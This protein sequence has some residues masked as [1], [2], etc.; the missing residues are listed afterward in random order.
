MNTGGGKRVPAAFVDPGLRRDDDQSGAQP[1]SSQALT[2]P[3][4]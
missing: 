3:S 1:A 2:S 4:S